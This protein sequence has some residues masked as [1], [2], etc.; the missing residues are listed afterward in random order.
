MVGASGAPNPRHSFREYPNFIP[1]FDSAVESLTFS[2]ERLGWWYRNARG[3]YFAVCKRNIPMQSDVA[4][5]V[6]NC[7][8]TFMSKTTEG[9]RCSH[10]LGRKPILI[11]IKVLEFLKPFSKGFKRSARQSLATF[12]CG[13]IPRPSSAEDLGWRYLNPC[14]SYSATCSRDF[15]IQGDVA[16]KVWIGS[17]TFMRK[18]T[19]GA[20]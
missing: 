12:G 7:R 17:K 11:V 1:R 9:A 14:G 6:W 3:S 16:P 10:T 15:P 5:K 8:K 20:R 18:T 13:R 2:A 19:E 4:P